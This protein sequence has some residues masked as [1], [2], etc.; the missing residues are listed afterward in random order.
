MNV[1]IIVAPRFDEATSY[2][3]E[4][5]REIKS[6]FEHSGYAVIDIS[7]RPVSRSEVEE[8]LKRNPN[9]LYIHYGH[10]NEDCH[11]G[12]A[13]EKIVDL[14]NVNILSNHEVYCVNCLS[15]K[16]LGVEAYKNGAIAY[17][18]YIENFVFTTD[19]L[20]EFRMFANAGL[21]F[22]L[23][24]NEWEKCLKLTKELANELYQKLIE[25]GKYIAAV[26]LRL[27]A[28]A[29]RCYTANNPP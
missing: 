16:K 12:S 2:T 28:D 20:D 15:A 13:N 14:K 1:A 21:K 10:G 9:S 11:Y 26:F 17:W 8:I 19:A 27:D 25:S 5:S 7:G 24:G 18:G 29:L 4:W 3:F 23:E 6:L 22:W